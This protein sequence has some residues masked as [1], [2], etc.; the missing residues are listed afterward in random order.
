MADTL[1]QTAIVSI[2][3]NGGGKKE[4]LAV[5]GSGNGY[6]LYIS[7]GQT[8]QQPV[9]LEGIAW[10]TERQG[11]PGKL[12]FTVVKNG[13]LSFQE[14]DT[15]IFKVGGAGIFYGYVFKKQRNKEQQIQVTAYDQL[16]Y[17]KNKH[18]YLYQNKRADEILNMIAGDF[19]L[20]VGSIDNTGYVI[21]S[22]IED[23]QTL[24]D[25]MQ[26]ALD[27]TLLAK[28]RTYVLYDEFGQLALKDIVNLKTDYYLDAE[29]AED[30][31]Y[32]SSIEDTYDKIQV[33]ED[34]DKGVRNYYIAQ[35]GENIAKWGMLQKT[36]KLNDGENGAEKAKQM[37][38]LYNQ[39]TRTLSISGALGSTK[40]RAGSLIAV[41]LSLGDVIANTYMLVE[42][43]SHTFSNGT[44][45][46]NLT[47]RGGGLI[48]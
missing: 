10:E 27:L 32:I 38:S 16:R 30:F 36:E 19:N 41:S 28:G 2:N 29:T 31:D 8:A 3:G 11:S 26:N 15:V 1:K 40:V 23:D 34:T 42:K 35:D 43:A 44:H 37:L 13:A 24:F 39:K 14:G 33:Y 20:R 47:L 45:T 5:D 7:D 22:R 6:E 48:T 46:M 9:V 25:I 18:T 21:K 17:F 4:Q 12:T